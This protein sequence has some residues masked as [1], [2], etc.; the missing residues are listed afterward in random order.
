MERRSN[1]ALLPLSPTLSF[2]F[3]AG[4]SA[5]ALAFSPSGARLAAAEKEGELFV[6]GGSALE[7]QARVDVSEHVRWI[8][9]GVGWRDEGTLLFSPLTHNLHLVRLPGAPVAAAATEVLS[10]RA[11]GSPHFGVFGFAFAPGAAEATCATSDGRIVIYSLEAG[12]VADSWVCHGD[13]INALCYL[14]GNG[15]AS[16]VIVSGSDDGLLQLS[17]R[18]DPRR[19]CGVLPGHRAGVTSVHARNDGF[20]LCSNAK[21]QS[22]K[23]W[24]VRRALSR[25]D[26]EQKPAGQRRFSAADFDYRWQMPGGSTFE[27]HPLDASVLTLRG[28]AV[29]RTLIRAK[30][31][32]LDVNGGRFI[33]AGGADG[34]CC[35]WDVLSG[36]PVPCAVLPRDTASIVR[37]LAWHPTQP[38]LVTGSYDSGRVQMHVAKPGGGEWVGAGSYAG[39]PGTTTQQVG[40]LMAL[41]RLKPYLRTL[42]NHLQG[43]TEGQRRR[44]L[45][46]KEQA[47]HAWF[48]IFERHR[49]PGASVHLDMGGDGEAEEEEE[50]EEEEE[51]DEDDDEDD[52][53][54]DDDDED[55]DEEEDDEDEEEAKED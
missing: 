48:Q 41:G 21:D 15:A 4:G 13:D 27:T 7:L 45:P 32:P 49:I 10:L 35:L 37:E 16:D 30:W 47:L 14:S 8:V 53:E 22:V 3:P 1:A 23:V 29:L 25:R 52:E 26:W 5:T 6:L 20:S 42:E 50:E 24:D 40:G 2:T 46:L 36:S 34:A 17:D 9:S 12:R 11:P 43:A 39:A 18:R 31:S 44:I 28:S 51:D 55:N 38:A 54:E 19:V 33:A